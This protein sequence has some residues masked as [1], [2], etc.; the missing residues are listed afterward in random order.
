MLVGERRAP[1]RRDR[2]PRLRAARR[3][4]SSASTSGAAPAARRGARRRPERERRRLRGP[5]RRRRSPSSARAA[6][7]RKLPISGEATNLA[8]GEAGRRTT[9]VIVL[10]A[11]AATVAALSGEPGYGELA[12]RLRRHE[13]GRGARTVEAVREL[14]RDGARLRRLLRPAR[15]ARARRLAGQGG[16]GAVRRLLRRD[17]AARAALGA[18]PDLEHDDDARRRA[19]GR[20]RDHAGGRRPPPAGRARLPE[21]GAAARCARG[22]WSGSRSG[23]C[24][25]TCSPRYFGSTFW[26][27][28]VGFGVDLTVVAR[29]SSWSA[30]SAPPLAALPAIRRGMRV[31]LRE[32][33]ESTGSAVGGQDAGDRLLRR[34]RFLPR[35]MQIGLRGVGRR[36]RRSLATALDRRA[37]GRQPARGP[38]ARGGGDRDATRA[39]WG[40][41]LEDIR[42]WTG[43]RRP[44]DERA[45]AGRSARPRASPRRSRRSST[46]S[47]SPARRRSC[48]A[49]RAS[50]S[51]ATGRDRRA[52]VQRR[53]GAGARAGRRDRAQPRPAHRHRRSATG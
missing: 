3:S 23:S 29:R 38:R 13:P 6:R 16:H 7:R 48:G 43:G 39:A 32:A 28:D 47:S 14:P 49:C 22:R 8:G 5:R 2:R 25:R 9:N 24:S 36:K 31:D 52:L 12:F 15:G 51:S 37:R 20:D 10:Y 27:I 42:I 26:A 53:R 41:H 21:D 33:L 1:A 35:T 19:D 17:H 44:F 34:V 50:R 46:T 11:T 30:C 45:A 18:R 40:D 4:T